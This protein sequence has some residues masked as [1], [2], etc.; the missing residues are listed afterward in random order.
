MTARVSHV[1]KRSPE[2]EITVNA[3]ADFLLIPMDA[4]LI[5]QV[6]INLLDNAIKHTSKENEISVTVAKDPE[7]HWVRFSV[8][9]R[10]HGHSGD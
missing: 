8:K 3:P 9:D 5:E 2:H 10:G 1:S 6:L 7:N 4:R